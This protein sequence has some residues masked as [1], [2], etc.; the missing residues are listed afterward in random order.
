MRRL[1]RRK[2]HRQDR[3]SLDALP[4]LFGLDP[5]PPRQLEEPRFISR[6]GNTFVAP[7]WF[8]EGLPTDP[9]DGELWMARGAF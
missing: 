6:Q 8:V 1:L 2:L 9:L 3:T 7:E 5:G 4:Q